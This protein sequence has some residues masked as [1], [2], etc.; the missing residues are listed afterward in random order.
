MR[1]KQARLQQ[2]SLPDT[3]EIDS[4]VKQTQGQPLESLNELALHWLRHF[5]LENPHDNQHSPFY[6]SHL[7]SDIFKETFVKLLV[8]VDEYVLLTLMDI[9]QHDEKLSLHMVQSI[10]ELHLDIYGR[11]T[12]PSSIVDDETRTLQ[13]DRL[14]RWASFASETINTK[15]QDRNVEGRHLMTRFLWSTVVC[16]DL[17]GSTTS[18]HTVSCYRDLVLLLQQEPD[19]NDSDIQI[20]NPADMAVSNNSIAILLVNNALMPELSISAAQKEISR[21]ITMNYFK[22][23]FESSDEDAFA[24]IDKLEPLLTLSLNSQQLS[25]ETD[26]ISGLSRTRSEGVSVSKFH[27]P[28]ILIREA[29]RF[30]DQASLSLKLV[31]WQKLRD[32]YSII[33]YPSMIL[34]CNLRSLALVVEHLESK[35][36]ANGSPEHESD[37]Y[38]HWAF[39]KLMI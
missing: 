18:E 38:L 15:Q 11:I 39:I 3:F 28:N 30:L 8:Q 19:S 26:P 10:F 16:N 17:L 13:R 36:Y 29:K 37:S 22:S 35:T 34:A 1:E 31:L 7:W 2:N 6:E 23:I 27:D 5:L 33:N 21:L 9:S 4:F 25:D 20:I 14:C 12:N 32:A 24:I